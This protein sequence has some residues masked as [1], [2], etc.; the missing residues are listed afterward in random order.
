MGS[1]YS[2]SPDSETNLNESYRI[3]T[4]YFYFAIRTL[5]EACVKLFALFCPAYLDRFIHTVLNSLDMSA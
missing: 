3:G 2:I 5:P 4:D 1:F